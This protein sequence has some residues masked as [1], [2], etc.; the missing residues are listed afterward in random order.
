MLFVVFFLVAFSIL[1][2]S[3][4]FVSLITIY[5]GVFLLGFILLGTLCA[6]WTWLTISFPMLGKVSAIIFSNIFSDPFCLSSSGTA[7][8]QMLV[9]LM[10]SQRY[11]RLSSFF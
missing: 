8:M 4:I 6:A 11:L 10:L 5:L 2:L 9:C 3:L 1:S 7:I